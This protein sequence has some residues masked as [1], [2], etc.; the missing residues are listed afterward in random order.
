MLILNP[1]SVFAPS[2]TTYFPVS[3]TP[4]RTLGENTDDAFGRDLDYRESADHKSE[5]EQ[6]MQDRPDHNCHFLKEC[7]ANE[8]KLH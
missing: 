4:S 6:Y 5:V 8:N 7:Y 3:K 2:G 1:E